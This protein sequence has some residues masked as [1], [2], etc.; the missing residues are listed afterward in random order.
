MLKALGNLGDFV[1]SHIRAWWNHRKEI[2]SPSFV[3]E[4]E[5]AEPAPRTTL[6]DNVIEAMLAASPTPEPG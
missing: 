4:V 6:A 3:E 1:G 5:R 2:F